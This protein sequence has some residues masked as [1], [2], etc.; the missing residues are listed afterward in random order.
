MQ[1]QTP[2]EQ[3][4]LAGMVAD[5]NSLLRLKTTVI[6]MKLFATVEEMTAIPKIRRPSA[7]HTTDQVV[8]NYLSMSFAAPATTLPR[9]Q[10]LI[11][12]DQFEELLTLTGSPDRAAC[13]GILRD[14]MAGSA[15][16]VAC[17]TS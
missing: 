12:I 6:G 8:S 2:S 4:D 7:I 16:V 17:S 15:T 14:A 11:V 3:F 13:A 5:L 10:L 9:R 1:L